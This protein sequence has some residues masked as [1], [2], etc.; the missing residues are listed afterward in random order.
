GICRYFAI[1]LLPLLPAA[2]WTQRVTATVTVGVSPVAVA[3][4]PVTNKIYVANCVPS[5]SRSPG[6]NGSVTVIDGKTNGKTGVS[7]G[8]CPGA[9]AV[10][11]LT[12]K[13]YVTNF[14]KFDLFCGSCIN[15]GSVTVIDGATNSTITITNPQA[16]FP[17][18]VAINSVTNKIYVANNL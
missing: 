11:P 1:G 6:V 15:Y 8:V 7:V 10:N 18:S 12:N 2:G 14:G 4:N 13:I 3:V 17:R 5:P 16:K 9:V